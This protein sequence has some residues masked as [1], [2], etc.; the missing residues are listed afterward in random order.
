M[1]TAPNEKEGL[2]A[3]DVSI[4]YEAERLRLK[5]N[6]VFAAM[7]VI[8]STV[9]ISLFTLHQPLAKVG[10]VFGLLVSLFTCYI[11]IYGATTLD[12]IAVQFEKQT[13]ENESRIKNAYE[14]FNLLPGNYMDLLKWMTVFSNV[15]LM[16]AS[17]IANLVLLSTLYSFR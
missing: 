15:A 2:L 1:N 13:P 7:M 14:L 9:G 3:L 11:T 12:W 4:G 8:Q 5:L 10:I 17:S 16:A 6:P